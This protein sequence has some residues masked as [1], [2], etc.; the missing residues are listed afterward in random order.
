MTDI[1]SS[2]RETLGL[3]KRDVCP[4]ADDILTGADAIAEFIFGDSR[5]RR[6]IY[7]L[8][9]KSRLPVFRLGAVLCARKSVLLSWIGEQEARAAAIDR[10]LGEPLRQPRASTPSVVVPRLKRSA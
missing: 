6:K 2:A 9:E 3:D 10:T 8:A 1:S 4:L 5:D 7:H